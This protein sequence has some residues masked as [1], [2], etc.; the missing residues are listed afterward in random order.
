M[1]TRSASPERRRLRPAQR[2]AGADVDF[3]KRHA[4]V[5]HQV[6]G[7]QHRVR[8]DAVGDEMQSILGDDDSLAKLVIAEMGERLDHVGLRGGTGNNFD[9]LQV[10]RRIE[11]VRACP[12]VL[13]LCRQA[14]G[15]AVHGE[16]GRC[17]W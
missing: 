8:A 12:V 3:F 11:E 13:P 7:I 10:A 15:D 6:N 2:G 4:Q 14:F 1:P 5:A 17:S 9:E 16:T